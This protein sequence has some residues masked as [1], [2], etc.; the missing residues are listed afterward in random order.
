MPIENAPAEIEYKLKFRFSV[1]FPES[2]GI[3]TWTVQS[4][5]P[6]KW[7]NGKWQDI[8]ISLTDTIS[9]RYSTSKALLNLT[10]EIKY[11][12][13]NL[14]LTIVL[15]DPAGSIISKWIITPSEYAV[16]LSNFDYSLNEILN[17]QLIIKVK[18]VEIV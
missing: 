10:K 18:K 4:V 16:V 15:Y 14:P 3:E 1:E 13:F 8:T 5:S 9:Q 6:L 17:N 12:K 7:E 2:L 11:N